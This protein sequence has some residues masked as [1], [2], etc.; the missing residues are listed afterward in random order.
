MNLNNIKLI[1]A[2]L[3]DTISELYKPASDK[4]I[5]YLNKLLE[6]GKAIIIISGQGKENIY[7]RVVCKIKRELRKNILVCGCGGAYIYGFGENG[8]FEDK[9][10]YSVYEESL[11][12][13][14]KKLWRE[15]IN[16]L[17]Q[18]FNLKIYKTMPKKEFTKIT[19][20]LS[21]AVIMEDRESQ[22]TFEVMNDL[23]LREKI[24]ARGKELM[25]E[26]NLPIGVFKGGEYAIDFMLY[27]VS[28]TYAVKFLMDN[29]NKLTKIGI[30]NPYELNDENIQVWGDK[31]SLTNGGTD[32]NML[33]G[34]N[35][36][37]L[38][39]DFRDEPIEEL[40]MT[41]NIKIWN[42]NKRLCEGLEEYLEL[43]LEG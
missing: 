16:Q 12:E 10:W 39:I 17:I 28:K 41:Y 43:N 6:E 33:Y 2:D 34:L 23:N 40:D 32:M 22:I 29:K 35:K 11:N 13:H 26:A 25:E 5:M 37:V 24:I 4:M 27:G 3:D 36:K 1:F 14:Q 18:E 38:A 31:Y 15:K 8:E 20:S 9:A 19:N 30:K 42:G 7:D 21:N